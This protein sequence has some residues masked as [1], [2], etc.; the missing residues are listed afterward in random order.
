MEVYLNQYFTFDTIPPPNADIKLVPGCCNFLSSH[1][2]TVLETYTFLP[3]TVGKHMLVPHFNMFLLQ[4]KEAWLKSADVAKMYPM[5]TR[6]SHSNLNSESLY[7]PEL[8]MATKKLPRMLPA[9]RSDNLDRIQEKRPITSIY[10]MLYGKRVKIN[11]SSS[12]TTTPTTETAGTS[13]TEKVAAT[14]VLKQ[15]Y[16]NVN[17]ISQNAFMS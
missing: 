16:E 11:L 7:V 10:D 17:D 9:L 6:M 4:A 15:D 14:L 8:K 12:G 13:G 1:T 3:V 5:V 2:H